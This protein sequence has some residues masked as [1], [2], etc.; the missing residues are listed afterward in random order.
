MDKI[1]DIKDND[2]YSQDLQESKDLLLLPLNLE[3]INYLLKI[4]PSKD[5]TSIIF[6]LEQEKIQTFYYYSKLDI[7]D[8]HKINKKFISDKTI[9]NI[10]LRLKDLTQDYSCLI[11]KFSL[12]INILFKKQNSEFS[13]IFSLRKKI[14]NQNKLNSDLVSQ[15]QENK[16][17]IKLLKKQITKLDKSIQSKNSQINNINNTLEKLANIANNINIKNIDSNDLDNIKPKNKNNDNDNKNNKNT[18]IKDDETDDLIKKLYTISEQENK[19]LKQ[20]LTLKENKSS[21]PEIEGKRFISNNRKKKNKNKLKEMKFILQKEKEKEESKENQIN[22]D[23]TL[24]CFENI[25]V[26]K[27]KKIYETL[28]VFNIMTVLIVMYLLCTIYT[29]RAET[30]FERIREQDFMKKIAFL[31]LLSDNSEDNDVGQMRENIVDFQL[32][33]NDD[34][35][36]NSS[37]HR[38]NH[39]FSKKKHEE[40]KA[41]SLMTEER[42]KRYYRKHIKRRIRHRIKE[43]SFDLKYNNKEPNRFRNFIYNNRIYEILILIKIKD[44]KKLGLFINNI[45][46]SDKDFEKDMDNDYVGFVYNNEQIHETSLEDFIFKFGNYLQSINNYLKGEKFRINNKYNISTKEF[47]DNIDIFEIYQVKYSR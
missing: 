6:K 34:N 21:E 43:I 33:N 15:I 40:L 10:F 1:M 27:N 19:L 37:N 42:E 13:P 44:G 28:I 25:D 18:T 31:S 32:K 2:N 3:Q 5:N 36:S 14:V 24:F 11:E 4:F 22:S 16:T 23:D 9:F 47:L 12:K 38:I 26:L 20:N 29:L 30:P 8:F 17:K 41:F 7:N 39:N 35:N 45:F 46:L